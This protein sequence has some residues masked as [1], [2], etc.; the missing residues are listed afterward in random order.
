MKVGIFKIAKPISF[1]SSVFNDFTEVE[2]MVK[3]LK[4]MNSD[5]T[6][7]TKKVK[8]YVGKNEIIVNGTTVKIVDF[9]EI[10]K[11]IEDDII[12]VIHGAINFFGGA[13]N[14]MITKT[15]FH[16]NHAKTDKKIFLFMDPVIPIIPLYM[17]KSTLINRKWNIYKESDVDDWVHK[18]IYILGSFYNHDFMKHKNKNVN[19]LD[20]YYVEFNAFPLILYPKQKITDF[21][22]Y[23]Y[24]YAGRYRYGARTRKLNAYFFGDMPEEIKRALVGNITK[25]NLS[26]M[27]SNISN[28]D[29]LGTLPLIPTNNKL[30]FYT[31]MNRC[32]STIGINDDSVNNISFNR[33]FF[34]SIVFNNVLFVDKLNDSNQL[35]FDGVDKKIKNFLYVSNKQQLIDNI[36]YLKHNMS[37]RYDIINSANAYIY[38]KYTY[39]YIFN[40]F[41]FAIDS[42]LKDGR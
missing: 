29:N 27:N 24:Y 7:Y 40:Q 35:F 15:Y 30:D 18:G 28:I 13:E 17:R 34:E 16:V 14:E 21:L 39:E 26:K 25:T 36:L 42:I 10:D 11:P 3:M 4:D 6:M 31:F 41:K 9:D 8:S 5:I 19:V 22:L 37:F 1:E 23:D 38:N 32:L 12:I 20:T 2:L 33:R